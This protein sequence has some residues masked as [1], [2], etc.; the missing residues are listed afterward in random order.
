MLKILYFLFIAKQSI[1]CMIYYQ[2]IIY[3]QVIMI[4]IDLVFMKK[5][6]K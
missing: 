1:H 5:Y 4:N 6:V 3:C 2:V